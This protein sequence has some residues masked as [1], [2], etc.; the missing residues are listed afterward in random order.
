MALNLPSAAELQAMF[1][2]VYQLIDVAGEDVVIR[3]NDGAGNYTDHP[4][5]KAKPRPVDL[6][7]IAAGTTARQGDFYLICRGD[8]FPVARPLQQKDRV[9]FRGR[10]LAI[11]NDDEN[12]H[13]IGGVVYAR[14]LHV[15]G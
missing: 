11:I 15:R 5:I 4:A 14:V 8:R 6:K 7:D 10:Q 1:A 13:S 3:E 2:P 12:Q 9:L